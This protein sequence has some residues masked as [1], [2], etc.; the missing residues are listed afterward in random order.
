MEK[1]DLK[2]FSKGPFKYQNTFN[3]APGKYT[4]KLVLSTGGEKFAKYETP[5]NI[6]PFDDKQLGISGPALSNDFRPVN[7]LVASLDSQLLVDQTPLLYGDMEVFPQPGNHF[8]RGDKVAFYVEVFE[9]R[10]RSASAP[11]VGVNFTIVDRKTNQQV[12]SS[13]TIVLDSVVRAGNPLIPMAQPVPT[14]NLQAGEYRLEV[15]AVNS[16]GGASPIR[17]ADFTLE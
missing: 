15:R 5:L 17:T 8:Q 9:P 7:Q 16:A 3:I 11:R 1:K 14:D 2:E 10:L 6:A 13:K 12:Y 4:L